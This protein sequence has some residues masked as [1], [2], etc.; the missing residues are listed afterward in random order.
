MHDS[1]MANPGP[2]GAPD[3]NTSGKV[4]LDI[5]AQPTGQYDV[6]GE[7][8]FQAERDGG[9]RVVL[10]RCRNEKIAR[11]LVE[12]LRERGGDNV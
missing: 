6:M 5:V 10:A 7:S 4:Y 3:I 9:R 12:A 2:M 8:E 11:A 1:N